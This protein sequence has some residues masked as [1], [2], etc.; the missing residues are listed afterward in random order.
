MDKMISFCGLDCTQCEA[1]QATQTNDE[2]AKK[3]VAEKWQKEFNIPPIETSF[4]TCDGCT[5][6]DKRL[7]GYCTQ[8]K[9]RACGI[10]R[11]VENCAYC[12]E[13]TSCTILNSFLANVPIAKANLEQIRTSIQ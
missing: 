10:A 4:V 3:I 2:A 5:H 11:G 9:I 1:Y 13:Y 6:L 8:C 12:D 7:S